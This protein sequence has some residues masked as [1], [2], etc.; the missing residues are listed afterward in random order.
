MDEA[1]YPGFE[2]MSNYGYMVP[3]NTPAT[4]VRQLQEALGKVVA[5]PSIQERF[6]AMGVNVAFGG[7]DELA[8]TLKGEI[9]RWGQVV[10]SANIKAE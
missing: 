1:G 7:P 4:I 2:A 6:Q 3:A 9:T 5:M 10:K 8:S